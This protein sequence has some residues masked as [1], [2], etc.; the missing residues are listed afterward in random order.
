MSLLDARQRAMLE[1]MGIRLFWPETADEAEPVFD[2]EPVLASDHVHELEAP[3]LAPAPA[4][5]P[6]VPQPAARP[7]VR[8]TPAAREPG[9]GIEVLAWDTGR[10]AV[11]GEVVDAFQADWLV[12]VDAPDDGVD[13]QGEPLA[14]QVAQ[15]LDNMLAALALARTDKVCIARVRGRAGGR[16]SDE[17]AAQCEPLLRHQVQ[18]LQPRIILALGTLAVKTLLQSAE[19]IGRLRGRVHRYAEVPVVVTYHPAY[20]LRN[21]QDKARAWADLVLARSVLA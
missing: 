18:V 3:V 8:P 6:A 11:T 19:P 21:Q 15:L 2:E 7:A 9:P 14:G 17:D 1:E 12:L 4:R 16:N 10:R 13:P 20:L 5:P